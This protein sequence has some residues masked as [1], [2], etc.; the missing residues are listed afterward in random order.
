[1]RRWWPAIAAVVFALLVTAGVGW[2][3]YLN[4]RP[5]SSGVAT[6]DVPLVVGGASFRVLDLQRLQRITFPDHDALVAPNG[7]VWV[8]LDAE[9]TLL[10]AA[11][12][13]AALSCYGVLASGDSEWT[14]S[15]D[16][17]TYAGDYEQKSCDKAGPDRP[18][19]PGVPKTLILY[20]L[21]P[22]WAADDARY[23]VRLSTPPRALELRP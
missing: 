17:A 9:V 10:D 7:A 11:V 3:R 6:R 12:D 5:L 23:F 4:L 15:Y 8:R 14:D 1:M 22:A 13:P 18:L 16:P 19:Q 21:V 2:G 20:W